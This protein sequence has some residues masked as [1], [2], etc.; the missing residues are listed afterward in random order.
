MPLYDSVSFI[1]IFELNPGV[2]TVRFACL[3]QANDSLLRLS[4]SVV[5]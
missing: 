4:Q 3:S 1:Y 5:Q 2:S